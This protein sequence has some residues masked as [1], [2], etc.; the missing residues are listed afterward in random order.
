ME[1]VGLGVGVIGLA[2]LFTA[3]LDALDRVRAFKSYTFDSEASRVQFDGHKLRLEEWGRN[4]GLK[5]G[6][7]GSGDH[8]RLRDPETMK[9][10][11]D[12]LNVIHQIIG[13]G[14]NQSSLLRRK[15]GKLSQASGSITTRQKL[16]WALGGKGTRANQ[17][18]LLGNLINQL[19]SLVPPPPVN[20]TEPANDMLDN[21]TWITGMR[22][23]LADIQAEKRRAVYAWILGDTSSSDSQEQFKDACK[24]RI[25]GTCDWILDRPA[26]QKWSSVDE[27]FP[28]LLWVHGV[29][30]SGKTMLASRMVEHLLQDLPDGSKRAV[31]HVFFSGEHASWSDPYTI[32]RLWLSQLAAHPA[33]Y[34][35]VSRAHTENE[36]REASR[37]T[38]VELLR[39]AS[40]T[41]SRLFL[42]IDGL[43]GC[44]ALAESTTSIARFLMDL[45]S[46][47]DGSLRVL[48]VSR[49]ETEIRQV[50][51]YSEPVNHITE[52]G[53][54][55]QDAQADVLAYS[56]TIVKQKLSRKIPGVTESLARSM[57]ERCDGQFLWLKFHEPSLMHWQNR[58]QL[59]KTL[60]R[61]PKGLE[62]IY[63]RTWEALTR[64]YEFERATIILRRVTFAR[65]PLTLGEISVAAHV[66]EGF[67]IEDLPDEISKEYVQSEILDICGPFIQIRQNPNE[68]VLERCTVHLHHFTVKQF[69]LTKLS[70]DILGL[71]D[72]LRVSH[73]QKQHTALLRHCIRYMR[74][75]HSSGDLEM[76]QL[77]KDYAISIGSSTQSQLLQGPLLEQ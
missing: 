65:R 48:V 4:V 73:E 43:D 64:N 45:R 67:D 54:I 6:Q 13:D 42:V 50:L 25:S 61:V 27:V 76:D 37:A 75:C 40:Q 36:S 11:E 49:D 12:T 46:L 19:H 52:Y 22:Q 47:L 26:F 29:P 59:Q 56:H 16:A 57:S 8:E 24:K 2:G 23:A 62:K 71:D 34:A 66:D 58:K 15:A 21:S 69:L 17:V 31:A 35:L 3:C 1:V 44:S 53:I 20:A 14:S 10:V 7:P 55:K 30:A 18:A 68:P 77:I 33:F 39:R 9:L 32:M 72:K 38:L 63:E 41:F 60:D 5:R 51:R 70:I 28:S 74:A